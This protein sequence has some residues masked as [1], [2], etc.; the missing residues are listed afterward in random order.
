MGSRVQ[1][2]IN[3]STNPKPHYWPELGPASGMCGH[4]QIIKNLLLLIAFSFFYLGSQEGTGFYPPSHL[5]PLSYS[6]FYHLTT[7]H[8]C[9]LFFFLTYTK[10]RLSLWSVTPLLRFTSWHVHSWGL[11]LFIVSQSPP[12]RVTTSWRICSFHVQAPTNLTW[13]Y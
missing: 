11:T 12:E 1:S 2:Q 10:L 4:I 5:K 8:L 6:R 13:V 9:S 3:D 7:L